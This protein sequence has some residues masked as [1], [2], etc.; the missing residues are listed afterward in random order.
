MEVPAGFES[1]NSKGK[2][3]NLKKA[4]HGL[5]QSPR[6]WFNWFTKAMVSFGYKLSNG[7]HTIFGTHQDS[8]II[9]L[10]V[11]MDDIIVTGKIWKKYQPWERSYQRSLKWMNLNNWSTS[12]VWKCQIRKDIMLSQHKH[13]MDLLSE[14]SKLGCKPANTAIKLN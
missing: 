12:W 6:A 2:V 1:V 14:T 10:I 11:Y 4:Q 5:K 3:C 7:D 8:K 9:I 13:V